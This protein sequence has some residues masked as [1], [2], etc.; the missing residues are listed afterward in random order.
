MKSRLPE[1]EDQKA[2]PPRYVGP[3]CPKSMTERGYRKFM[4]KSETVEVGGVAYTLQNPSPRWYLQCT[5]RN[6]DANGNLDLEDYLDEL[7]KNCVVS[8]ADVRNR[9][10][11]CFDDAE[12]LQGALQLRKAMERFLLK[13]KEKTTGPG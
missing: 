9:G 3:P 11:A 6:R 8:P 7:F 5:T 10:L 2:A 1:Q 12:D 13:P 4:A